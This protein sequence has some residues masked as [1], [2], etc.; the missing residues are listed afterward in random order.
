[1]SNFGGGRLVLVGRFFYNCYFA[2]PHL[3]LYHL[4]IRYS[5]LDTLRVVPVFR[6]LL[7][8][9]ISR[10]TPAV[11]GSIQV[12]EESRRHPIERSVITSQKYIL[13]I[14]IIA[15]YWCN[16][17]QFQLLMLRSKV[18]ETRFQFSQNTNIIRKF[19]KIFCSYDKI[20]WDRTN[21]QNMHA[22]HPHIKTNQFST[23]YICIALDIPISLA[24]CLK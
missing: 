1:M 16:S 19:S 4:L 21:I 5:L 6:P 15:K 10:T 22:K 3:Y 24:R 14:L 2:K 20:I 11:S 7:D 18:N 13:K 8:Q 23:M 12:F 9:Q 17:F